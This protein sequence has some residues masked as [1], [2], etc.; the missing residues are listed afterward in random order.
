MKIEIGIL[1]VLPFSIAELRMGIF[2][3]Y[4]Q[5]IVMILKVELTQENKKFVMK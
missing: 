2:P 4:Q 5:V 3:M 1:M